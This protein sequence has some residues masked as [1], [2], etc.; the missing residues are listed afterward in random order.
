MVKQE[1]YSEDE[2]SINQL[3]CETSS[4]PL[5]TTSLINNKTRLS[6][7]NCDSFSEPI[8]TPEHSTLYPD[9]SDL[10]DNIRTTPSPPEL[11]ENKSSC[12]VG[13]KGLEPTLLQVSRVKREREDSLDLRD[14]I[15]KGVEV[16]LNDQVRTF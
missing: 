4:L 13:E 5:D 3:N 10:C 9:P 2:E 12:K 8:L 11:Q 7:R 14:I 16:T 1:A 6:P 15:H